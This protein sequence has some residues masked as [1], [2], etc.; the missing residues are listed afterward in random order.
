[1][2]NLEPDVLFAKGTRRVGDNVF[3]AL[4]YCQSIANYSSQSVIIPP[5]FAGTFVVACI[6]YRG[7][8]R[9]RWLSRNAGPC[10]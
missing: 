5:N 3:E 4:E 2:A 8:S 7:G 6:L 10:A 1:M 9:S